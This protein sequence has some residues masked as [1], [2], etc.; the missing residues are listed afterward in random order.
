MSIEQHLR[1]AAGHLAR[2][3]LAPARAELEALRA[4]APCDVRT[5]LLSV[6]VALGE[7][8]IRDAT[9]EALAAAQAV[10]AEPL[11]LLATVEALL[12]VG[13]VTAARQCLGSPVLA[14]LDDPPSLLRMARQRQRLDENA[15]ALRL[16]ER[17]L[18][19][20][21]D[22][23]ACRLDHGVQL[24]FNGRI[25]DAERRLE[26][27][28]R[29]SPRLGRTALAL[30][31]LRRRSGDDHHLDLIATGLEQVSRG[32]PDHA[33]LLFALYKELDDLG[34]FDEAWRAL[35]QGNAV[36]RARRPWD[37]DGE[38][39]YVDKLLS[40]CEGERVVPRGPIDPG[41]Q[42]VF[43]LGMPRSGSTVLERMLGN[44]SRV[45]SA[46]ELVDFGM[47]LHWLADTANTH[48]D[49][50]ISRIAGLDLAE[51]GRRYLAR[52]RWRAG[53][54]DFFIDKQ[55]PNWTFAGL[56]HAALPGARLLH[57]V[58]DPMDVCFSNWRAFFGDTYAYSYDMAA[59][60]AYHRDYRRAMARWHAVM[61]GA[62]LDVPYADL[63]RQPEATL[64]K[65]LGF[66][67]LDFEPA[68][69][70]LTRNAAPSATLSAAQVRAP[71]HARAF[72]EWRQYAAQL[73]P[74]H[75]KVTHGRTGKL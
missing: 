21:A 7:D 27:S 37:P 53:D 63:V 51:A 61:P 49:A 15:A 39:R 48:S 3:R 55:P 13:E 56:I 31:R 73:E 75:R 9:R 8:R 60:A 11:L 30:A 64:R 22:D 34:R 17:A 71:L 40:A 59:L 58:R 68:C 25:A 74:L 32:T 41:A 36:M 35:A 67:G 1:D 10:P 33:A 23:P 14:R 57:V 42:P 47:Q 50:F 43:I 5:R 38:S 28:L 26:A 19:L 45:G 29:A 70:D 44:H 4:V 65:V 20:G 18:A 46:A 62:I 72:G 12:D 6:R 16:I 24:Y 69:T 2:G 52:T 66:C 54:K